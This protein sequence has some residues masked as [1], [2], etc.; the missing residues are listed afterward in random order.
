[1]SAIIRF[2]SFSVYILSLSKLSTIF[3][4]TICLDLIGYTPIDEKALGTYHIGLGMNHLFGGQ[5]NCKFH[6]DFVFTCHDITFS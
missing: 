5:N 3:S 4:K 6:M 1:M 2:T